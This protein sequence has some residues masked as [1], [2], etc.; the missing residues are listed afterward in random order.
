MKIITADPT[1][2]CFGVKRAVARLEKVL[3]EEGPVYSIGS[4]IHNPQEIERLKSSGLIVVASPEDVPQGAVSFIRAHGISPGIFAELER[5][6]V[7]IVDGT[8]PFVKNAQVHAKKLSKEGYLVVISGDEV[9]PEVQG[10]IGFAG[11]SNGN[12][13]VI[14]SGGRIPENAK[15]RRCGILSQ[16]TQKA[17][18]FAALVKAFVPFSPEMKVYNTICRAT[19]ER[20][21]S[22]RRLASRVDGMIVL[23]GQNSA[24]TRRLAEIA[25][26]AGVS[27][28]WIEH[29]EELNRGWLQ[30]RETIGIAAGGSTPDWLINKLIEKLQ[31]M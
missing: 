2:L 7:R 19:L 23:G 9:H 24:N 28:L 4:P 17:A 5:R 8:C 6:S 26:E 25:S 14:P 31:M 1:G 30:N 18:D 13:V 20:Q 27:A 15:G 22:V 29:Y 3:T 12:V 21:E 11:Y 10:I 16:T